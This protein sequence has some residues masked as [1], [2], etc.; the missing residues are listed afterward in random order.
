MVKFLQSSHPLVAHFEAALLQRQRVEILL[1]ASVFPVCDVKLFNL[2]KSINPNAEVDP[3]I[4]L[5]LTMKAA[6]QSNFIYTS[7]DNLWISR[8]TSGGIQPL[9]ENNSIATENIQTEAIFIPC[10][11]KKPVEAFHLEVAANEYYVDVIAQKLGVMD[12]SQV[13]IS[14]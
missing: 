4:P 2:C 1:P 12:S 3:L 13:L 10:C 7:R 9:F 11:T 14:R 6:K 8:Q 5:A